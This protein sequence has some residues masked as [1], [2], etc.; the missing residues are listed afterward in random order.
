MYVH[1]PTHSK[2]KKKDAEN[3]CGVFIMPAGF[4]VTSGAGFQHL[5]YPHF[6][7]TPTAKET[8]GFGD[9][10]LL[11]PNVTCSTDPSEYQKLKFSKKMSEQTLSK[12]LSSGLSCAPPWTD[13]RHYSNLLAKSRLPVPVKTHPKARQP[14]PQKK[15]LLAPS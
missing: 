9:T 12:S 3:K 1:I 7:I 10:I 6:S 11:A 14:P 2:K 8:K 15:S 4:H 5:S 13:T